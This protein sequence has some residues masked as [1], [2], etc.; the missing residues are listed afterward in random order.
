VGVN[1]FG[2]CHIFANDDLATKPIALLLPALSYQFQNLLDCFVEFILV[3]KHFQVHNVMHL[4]ADPYF[5]RQLELWR[6][7]EWVVRENSINSPSHVNHKRSTLC[8]QSGSVYHHVF[9]HGQSLPSLD[10]I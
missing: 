6:P 1:G 7:Y 5:R 8:D 9:G 4:A 10:G 2:C 3:I